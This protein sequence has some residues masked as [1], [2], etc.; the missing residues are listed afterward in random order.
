MQGT[1]KAHSNIALIKYW[2]KRNEKL[3]LPA[4]NS[5]SMT[6]DQYYTT[7]T[8]SFDPYLETDQ[9][10]FNDN[11]ANEKER[12]R[13][14][15]FLDQIRSLTK[16][17]Y[18]ATV[19]SINSVPTAAGLASSA[20]GFAALAAAASKALDLD[21]DKRTLSR[22]AR[23]GSG[24]ACRSIYGGFVEWQKGNRNDGMDS[25]AAPVA[26]SEH[27]NLAM[28]IACVDITRKNVSSREGMNA[29]VRTSPFYQGWLTTVEQDLIKAKRAVLA[30]DF[31]KLG[32]IVE[33]NALKMHAVALG[34][35]P[36]II[37][38]QEP[39]L[40]VIEKVQALRKAGVPAYFTIDAGPNVAVLC[41]QQNVP[42]V[43]ETLLEVPDVMNLKICYPGP[44]IA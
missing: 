43:H 5:L 30:R 34:A 27:W 22:L 39:T 32:S 1:A 19:T 18:H 28:V 8:V 31:E 25:Y 16:T 2:G 37:Y 29:S 3:I 21:L 13:V 41:E 38:W 4:N 33:S 36:P 44:D 15:R 6:L 9:F 35:N 20:S 23:L 10:L 12:A 17:N 42:V 26:P 11:Q 24:S 7:T 14:S 40:S